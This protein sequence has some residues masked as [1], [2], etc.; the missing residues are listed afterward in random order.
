ME[1]FRSIYLYPAFTKSI[2]SDVFLE[3]L[4]EGR[5]KVKDSKTHNVP[6]VERGFLAG[7]K[8]EGLVSMIKQHTISEWGHEVEERIKKARAAAETPNLK[9]GGK[10]LLCIG[11][12]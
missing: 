12:H 9:S 2:I 10:N 8:T 6:V 7:V 11:I 1:L 5:S 3:T 4:E